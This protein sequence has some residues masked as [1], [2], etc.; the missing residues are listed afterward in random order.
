[1]SDLATDGSGTAEIGQPT[2]VTRRELRWRIWVQLPLIIALVLLWM[3]LWGT[4][5]LF[6]LVTGVAVAFAVTSVFYLPPVELSGRFNP[7]WFIVFIGR[8]AVDLVVASFQVAFQALGPRGIRRNSVI[9][10]DLVTRSDFIMTLT[11][12]AIS[13][14][15]GSIVVEVDRRHSILYLHALNVGDDEAV[16]QT[17]LKV[18]SVE[19]SLVRALGSAE[20]VRDTGVLAG[21]GPTAGIPIV[22]PRDG[23][24]S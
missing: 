13:L 11:A 5:S 9:A 8:F 24:E 21:S 19:R 1:M 12:V 2:P 20:D 10:V 14:I 23:A 16:I 15:P 22:E 17:R 3:L 18:L 7:F 4:F 6:S